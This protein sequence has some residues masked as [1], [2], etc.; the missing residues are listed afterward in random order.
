MSISNGIAK[1]Q[2]IHLSTIELELLGACRDVTERQHEMLPAL[3]QMMGVVE[4]E[5]FYTWAFRR[6]RQRWKLDGTDWRVFFHGL[7]CDLENLSDGR[8]LRLDFGPGGGVNTFT[9]W[10]V[11]QFVMTSTA[12]WVEYTALKH[13]FAA[14][15]SPTNGF[16]GDMAAIDQVWDQLE[17]KGVFQPADRAL[18]DFQA[19]WTVIGSDGLRRIHYP[20]ATSETTR[21]DCSVAHRPTLSPLGLRFLEECLVGQEEGSHT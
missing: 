1:K 14:V 13:R 11:L 10:G 15:G 17:A 20:P 6:C 19:Q 16:G 5:V 8:L 3:A 21:M 12:P 18:M 9:M 4:E 7:E 2:G